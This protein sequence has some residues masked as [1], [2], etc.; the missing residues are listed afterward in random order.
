[1][2]L[3]GNT[4]GVTYKGQWVSWPEKFDDTRDKVLALGEPRVEIIDDYWPTPKGQL[5]HIVN[6]LVLP[7]VKP[8]DVLFIEPDHVFSEE[9]RSFQMECVC[10]TL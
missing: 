8:L 6:D 2:K 10:K 9:K 5:T 3:Q 4:D 7:R 1:L